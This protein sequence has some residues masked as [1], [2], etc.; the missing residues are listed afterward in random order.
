M[1]KSL[2]LCF[3]KKNPSCVLGVPTLYE[4][5]MSNN[6]VKNLDL[7]NLKYIVSGGDTL[8]KSLEIK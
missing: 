3:I 6:N 7:S 5:L 2:I 1:L 8:P 4:A